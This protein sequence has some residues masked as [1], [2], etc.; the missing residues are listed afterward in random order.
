M[1]SRIDDMG[2][3]EQISEAFE[4][5]AASYSHAARNTHK[6]GLYSN[7]LIDSAPVDNRFLQ[8]P[9]HVSVA[10]CLYRNQG[11]APT[12]THAKLFSQ[13]GPRINLGL[14]R[15][16]LSRRATRINFLF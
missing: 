10:L 15:S 14:L 3:N 7:R 5:P 2:R 11:R 6:A 1:I 16:F 13:A 12:A 9:I 8:R 4:R